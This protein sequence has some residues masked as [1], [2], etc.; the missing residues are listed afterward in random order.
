VTDRSPTAGARRRLL[1][2]LRSSLLGLAALVGGMQVAGARSSLPPAVLG[3]LDL[4][5]N[6]D[7]T[8]PQDALLVDDAGRPLRF[9]DLFG[10]RPV[11]LFFEYFRCP[12]LCGIVGANLVQA[13]DGLDLAPGRD[14]EVAVI[15]LDP[16]ETSADAAAAKRQDLE[17]Y[18]RPW[19]AGGWHFL[20]GS[21]PALGRLADA[22]GFPFVADP[23]Q[24]GYAHPTGLILA[25]QD[26]VLARYLPGIDFPVAD[27]RL[28]L[29]DTSGGRIA[30]PAARL[31]LLCYSYDPQTGRYTVTAETLVR[32]TGIATV[33]ALAVL[34]GGLAR[35]ERRR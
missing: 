8:L 17:R 11:L 30:A 1:C 23:E 5:Q 33:V 12:N 6:L 9:G 14:F 21:A 3:N 31:L 35:S 2:I 28:A 20:T 10:K 29:V 13:L 16:R 25:T 26:G 34:I 18:G 19:T 27:L 22:A 24:G 4:V 32:A 15:S 7:A